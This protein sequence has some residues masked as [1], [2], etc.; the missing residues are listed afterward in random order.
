MRSGGGGGGGCMSGLSCALPVSSTMCA[1]S[2]RVLPHRVVRPSITPSVFVWGRR[3]C[4]GSAAATAVRRP[5]T[6]AEAE[7]DLQAWTRSTAATASSPTTLT[8]SGRSLVRCVAALQLHEAAEGSEREAPVRE[9][10]HALAQHIY[11]HHNA[12]GRP[13]AASVLLADVESGAVG[14]ESLRSAVQYLAHR[15]FQHSSGS[16]STLN[17]PSPAALTAAE[18]DLDLSLEATLALLAGHALAQVHATPAE[19]KETETE[20]ATAAM[21]PHAE[22][23][24]FYISNVIALNA[25]AAGDDDATW[26]SAKRAYWT[27][28]AKQLSSVLYVALLAVQADSVDGQRV[29]WLLRDVLR[30]AYGVGDGRFGVVRSAH[31][32]ATVAAPYARRS[33]ASIMHVLRQRQHRAKAAAEVGRD[34]QPRAAGGASGSSGSPTDRRRLLTLVVLCAAA[35][36]YLASSSTKVLAAMPSWTSSSSSTAASATAPAGD[37]HNTYKRLTAMAASATAPPPT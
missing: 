26:P 11:L 15:A 30:R 7:A 29:G 3:W 13:C 19:A 33:V 28:E 5:P 21:V 12:A 2:T 24:H 10:L 14:C 37:S 35:V 6:A 34:R 4:T 16:T 18:R 17:V 23:A 20:V 8:V 32:I 22:S 36:L 1:S 9:Y 31:Y 25:V 27:Q